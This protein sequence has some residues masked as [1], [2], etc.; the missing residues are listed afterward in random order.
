MGRLNDVL[1]QVLA[2][3]CN[4]VDLAKAQAVYVIK[5][6]LGKFVGEQAVENDPQC[7]LIVGRFRNG[8]RWDLTGEGQPEFGSSILDGAANREVAVRT[9]LGHVNSVL[10]GFSGCAKVANLEVSLGIHENIFWLQVPMNNA[11]VV[12]RLEA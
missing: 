7:I 4:G 11:A 3:F 12:N 10:L 9:H 1:R 6:W 5:A 2:V 8:F